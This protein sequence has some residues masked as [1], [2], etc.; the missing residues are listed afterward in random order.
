[1]LLSET[2]RDR[3]IYMAYV[4]LMEVA[5]A[6]GDMDQALAWADRVRPGVGLSGNIHISIWAGIG[7]ALSAAGRYDEAREAFEKAVG[8]RDRARGFSQDAGI[9]AGGG[10]FPGKR[11]SG[12]CT[13]ARR[14]CQSGI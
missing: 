11:E 4:L 13:V 3:L 2:G 12:I 9:Y 1:M 10:I 5:V 7:K 6:S 8:V 14:G